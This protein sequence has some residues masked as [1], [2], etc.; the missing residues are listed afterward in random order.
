LYTTHVALEKESVQRNGLVIIAGASQPV[1]LDTYDRKLTKK[2]SSIIGPG[3]SK[4]NAFHFCYK[5]K[6]VIGY[7]LPVILYLMGSKYRE[8]VLIH[9]GTKKEIAQKLEQV[10]GIPMSILPTDIGGEKI[11][12]QSEW[13]EGRRAE[14]R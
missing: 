9:T 14:N 7:L 6:G 8:S 12:S 4:V 13:V 2:M 1:R 11:F 10:Y 3:F 5:D